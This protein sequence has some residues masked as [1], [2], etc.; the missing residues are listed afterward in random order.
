M[1]K[2]NS[3]R[4]SNHKRDE[5]EKPKSQ[6]SS[7]CTYRYNSHFTTRVTRVLHTATRT[8]RDEIRSKT[9]NETIELWRSRTR[10]KSSRV[11][12]GRDRN[13]RRRG[14]RSTVSESKAK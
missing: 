13:P 1:H 14:L 2:I 10:S 12:V 4:F 9:I 3:T 11:A 8:C 5:R 6:I 7:A